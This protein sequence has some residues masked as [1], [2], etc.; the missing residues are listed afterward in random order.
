MK[1][2]FIPI[3]SLIL[4]VSST[5]QARYFT[6]FTEIPAWGMNAIETVESADIMKGF[7]DGSFRPN[8]EIN[9]AEAVTILLRLKKID[10]ENIT[11][12]DYFPDVPT[13]V[14]FAKAV[15][16]A[17][18]K[19]WIRGKSDGLF[20]P[21]DKI[22][23]AEFATILTRAFDLDTE[24]VP[25]NSFR[26]IPTKA[27]YAKSVSSVLDIDLLR[28]PRSLFYYPEKHVSRAEAAWTFAKILGMPRLN[29]TSK[30]N[31]FE[32][33]KAT[34]ARRVAYKPRNFNKYKQSIE[35]E[36]K[37]VI[38]NTQANGEL[39][40]INKNSG[41]IDLGTVTVKNTL[42]GRADLDN[43]RFKLRFKEPN[44]GPVSNFTVRM[45]SQANAYEKELSNAKTGEYAFTGLDQS[46]QPDESITFTLAIKPQSEQ[47]FYSRSG[48]ALFSIIAGQAFHTETSV[49]DRTN[50]NTLVKFTPIQF[51][52]QKLSSIRFTP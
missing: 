41:W 21:S 12:Q 3:L 25:P 48:D 20:H 38:I 33:K 47:Q 39:L 43:L 8:R 14:W 31:N 5:T 1:K 24:N 49:R 27:W 28:S 51:E 2:T 30:T 17:S 15:T 40:A 34:N 18:E 29:G 52:T 35:T 42:E 32:K 4:F 23:R 36:K 16:I 22:N 11:P 44:T 37:G 26:D 9:R 10:T 13:D 50:Q 46:I 19:G 45:R 7:G 6:D